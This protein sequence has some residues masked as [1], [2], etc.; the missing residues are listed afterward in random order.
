M[1]KVAIIDDHKLIRDSLKLMIS[2]FSNMEVV[3]ESVNDPILLQKINDKKVDIILLHIQVPHVQSYEACIRLHELYPNSKILILSQY[4]DKY[5]IRKI[6]ECG[7]HGY[8]SKNS[9]PEQFQKAIVSIHKKGFYFDADIAEVL[10]DILLI[11]KNSNKLSDPLG[12]LS[13]REMEVIKLAAKGHPNTLIADKMFINVRTVEA[14]RK[15]IMEKA[16][17]KNFTNVILK[18]LKHH[19]LTIRDL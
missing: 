8:L 13:D 16:G 6:V 18:A 11:G 15:R 14:H 17:A 2:S 5:S 10:H 9:D 12:K 1:L 3:F 19:Y 4:D 7:A